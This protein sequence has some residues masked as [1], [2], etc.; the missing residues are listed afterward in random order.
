MEISCG[1][2][3]VTFILFWCVLAPMVFPTIDWS[4]FVS[5]WMGFRLI[6]IH[7][8]PFIATYTNLYLSE[9]TMIP[10]DWKMVTAVGVSYQFANAIGT[11]MMQAPLY[12]IADWKNVPLTSAL[13]TIAGCFMGYFFY[14]AA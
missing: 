3:A 13:W 1:I 4:D 11:W 5:A 10:S 2:N 8:F 12:P 7:T 14:L 9:V 6:F